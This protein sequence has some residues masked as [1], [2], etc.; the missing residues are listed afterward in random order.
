[1]QEAEQL[2]LSVFMACIH[3]EDIN[4][5]QNQGLEVNNHNEPAQENV[6]LSNQTQQTM[7]QIRVSHGDLVALIN[8]QLLQLSTSPK[9][10]KEVGS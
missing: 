1:M 7:N 5:I 4:F 2:D 9:N 3:A 6:P 10:P 8:K